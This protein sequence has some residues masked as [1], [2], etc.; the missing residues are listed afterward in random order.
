MA[1]R[2]C[3]NVS[4]EKWSECESETDREAETLGERMCVLVQERESEGECEC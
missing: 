3:M 2:V 4:R 1:V